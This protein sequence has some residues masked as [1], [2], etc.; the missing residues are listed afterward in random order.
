MEDWIAVEVTRTGDIKHL[1]W[2]GNI[3]SDKRSFQMC[4][5]YILGDTSNWEEKKSALE[6]MSFHG[7]GVV[8]KCTDDD[9]LEFLNESWAPQLI[10]T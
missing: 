1:P 2:Y 4:E 6:A 9:L 8:G 7:M 3:F 5:A 10:Q